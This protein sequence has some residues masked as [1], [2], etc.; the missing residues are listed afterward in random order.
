M[1]A[2]LGIPLVVLSIAALAGYPLLTGDNLVQSYP[3]SV[4]AGEIIAHGHL[5]VYDPYLWAGSPLLAGANAHALLPS[6]LLFAF[7]PHLTAWVL[8]EALTLGA[9]AIGG[10]VLLRR[11]FCRTLAATLGGASFGLGGFVS[12]QIVH[13]DFVSAA[14]AVVW[15]L[16]A[17]DAIFQGEARW[18]APW[19]VVLAVAAGCIGL[20]GSPDIVVDA[21]VAVVVYGGHLLIGA[22][23]RRGVCLGWTV[24]AGLAGLALGAVQWLPTA[25]FVAV[26]E[27]AHASYAFAASGSVSPAELLIS[28]VPHVLGGGP[29]GLETYTGPYNLAELDAY[30]GILA[31]V[32]IPALATRWRSEHA[33]RWRV[34]Y[35]V[36]AIG[37]LLALG[38][39]TPLEHVIQRF[40][41]VGEQRLPSRALILFS[42]ASSLLLG[43]WAED[44]LAAQP[45]RVRWASVLG[46]AVAPAVVLGLVVATA[47]TGKPYGGL[48][49]AVAGSHWSLG[50][51]APYLAV[52]A[53]IA[54]AAGLV[55]VLGPSWPRRRFA[56]VITAVVIADLLVFTANQ[57]SLAPVYS[58]GLDTA[59]SLRAQ[60]AARLAN[61]GRYL[62]VDPG[63][64]AGVALDQVGASDFNLLS[65]L[66][67]AQGYGSLTW[68]PYASATGTHSQDDL[69]PAALAT[70]T[71]DSL[72]VRLLLTVPDELSAV[73][74]QPERPGSAPASP[75]GLGLPP[76]AGVQP[77]PSSI[78][79]RPGQ[80][81]TRWFGRSLVLRSVTFEL[82][83]PLSSSRAA[84]RLG[85]AVR[86]AFAPGNGRAATGP[87]AVSLPGK[88]EVVV[89]FKAP[90]ATVGLVTANPLDS[91]V[92]IASVTV[93]T[94]SGISYGLNGALSS[95]LT[96]PHWMAAGTI[97]PFAVFTNTRARGAFS[98]TGPGGGRTGGGFRFRVVHASPWTPTE[99][100]AVT[101]RVP[102]TV[103]RSVADIPGW[104]AI[105]EHDGHTRKIGLRRDGLVQSF[106]VA[107]GTS[108]VT[109]TYDQPGLR[110]GLAGSAAGIVA[111]LL[112]AVAALARR[113]RRSRRSR[114]QVQ[115]RPDGG[116][117]PGPAA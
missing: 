57:S 58:R 104:S 8:A 85:H 28:L 61:G 82:S 29:I 18:R 79:L 52:T 109:F 32:A 35:L 98:A 47:L 91:S 62:V 6:T 4:L 92:R 78:D 65:G 41:L 66:A 69:D 49:H 48:L 46:G 80:V 23:G 73:G 1:G 116:L 44:Q 72:D 13:V 30:C 111:L 9:G 36:G 31:L 17:L 90:R 2:L 15:G 53:V 56:S 99:T 14:A 81:A 93:T 11:N 88:R 45:G 105:D 75:P 77:V 19:A 60:L 71:F 97:G 108:I 12:S 115:A 113:T 43:Y 20:S 74:R 110:A 87:V 24:F 25:E 22:R 84:M 106:A 63:R 76:I 64:S 114:R 7:L 89:S 107:K 68:G 96:G 59:N 39:H 101:A 86:L 26:S 34:W 67:S 38:A 55:V 27:R 33:S 54:A 94:R 117:A 100:V 5:P 40:P 50:A 42:L 103:V 37:L 95:Y 102:T 16:V 112:L 21:A 3:L 83:A 51:I 10:F 70:G